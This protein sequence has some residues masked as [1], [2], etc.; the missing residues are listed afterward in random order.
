MLKVENLQ[1]FYGKNQVL[2]GMV[3]EVGVGKIVALL[4]RNGSGRSTVAKA[5]MG[6]VQARGSVLWKGQEILG[7][8]PH[9][10][11]QL[12][13]GYVP[14]G[15]DVF[16]TLSVEQNLILGQKP[17]ASSVA[18]QAAWSLGDMYAMFPVL[19]DRC[20][21]RA[22]VLSGGEQQMLSLCRTLMGNPELLIVDEPT[23]GLAPQLVTQVAELLKTLKARGMSVLL[24]E[25]KLTIALAISDSCYVLGHGKTV[26]AGTPAALLDRDDIQREWLGV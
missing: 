26:F 2:L 17:T 15:R 10:I 20:H 21:T 6:L 14:E 12:G 1:A 11:A 19:K 8:P 24:I 5:L 13:L 18:K 16:P 23:E 25:Q 4:G 3:M 9:Q 22:E 7:K